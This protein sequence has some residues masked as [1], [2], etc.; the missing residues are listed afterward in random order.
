MSDVRVFITKHST[1]W[2]REIAD[3]NTVLRT[4]VGSGLHGVTVKEADDRDEMGIAI[5]PP[6]VALGRNP[7]AFEQYEYRSQPVGVRSGPGDLDLVVYSLRKYVRLASAGNPTVLMPLFAPDAEIVRIAEP[8]LDLRANALMLLS[9]KAG[10]RFL[11]YM[12][13]Q[14]R[15]LAGESA[16]RLNRPELIEQY[17]YDT[18]YAYH[19][20]R[21][22]I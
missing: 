14:R 22:A 15:H 4:Q 11:G 10:L 8:G 5:E 1:D 3:D 13:S 12:N 6:E 7:K 20:M 17:G 16:P 9:K 21:I 19:S 2:H 18:K